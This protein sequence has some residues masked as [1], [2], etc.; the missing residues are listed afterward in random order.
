MPCHT[1]I[2][3]EVEPLMQDTIERLGHEHTLAATVLIAGIPREVAVIL[4]QAV[5]AERSSLRTERPRCPNH[6]EIGE[7]AP[8]DVAL[9]VSPNQRTSN[10][11][12][13]V[14]CALSVFV[15]FS[16]AA[17]LL[18]YVSGVTVSARTVWSWVREAGSKAMRELQR[19]LGGSES[20]KV[21]DEDVDST[22]AA[23]PLVLG[24]DGVMVPFRPARPP[25]V[26]GQSGVK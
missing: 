10:E 22:V 20:G 21:P 18:Q 1:Y 25:R 6:C 16:T 11:L 26:D 5:L 13:N 8:F 19:Q 4:L 7:V 9:G 2:L 17:L 14:A 24:A 23:F 3:S 12:K 15:P